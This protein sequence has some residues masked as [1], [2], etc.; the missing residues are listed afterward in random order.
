MTLQLKNKKW[1]IVYVISFLLFSFTGNAAIPEEPEEEILFVTSYNSDT[2]YTYDNINTFVETYRQL[3]GKYSTIVENMNVTDLNQSRK[4]KKRLTNILDKH[5]NAKLVILLGGE[6][7]SSFLHLEDEKY[8]QLPV[9]C[10]MASRN[11]IRI[12]EDSIDIRT[13]EPQ[14]IDLTERM[15]KYNIIYCNTY[16]YDIDK[17][18]EMMRSFYP[19]M[20]H[21]V[22]ISDNTYNGLAEQAWVKKNMKRYPEISTTYIDG[23][24]HTLDAAVKQ[25]RDVPKNSVALLGIWRI[26]N[27]GITYMNNSVYAFS[28]ANPELPVFS[29]TATAI[30]YWAI[31][32]YIPQYDGIGKSMG[33]QAYQFLDKGKNNVGHIHLLPNRYKFDANKLHEWG[34]QDKK[35]PFNSLIINQQ[36]PFF[37]AYR[38]EVQFILFTFLVLI[39][40]LFISLYY[41]YRTKILK[42]HLEKTTAQLR[43]DKKKLELSEIALRHAKERAEEA[44]Q[45]K[46][47]FV[48][49]MS[50]EIRTPLNAIVGFSRIISESENPEER[51]E[52]YE[53]VDANNER[54]LQ[55]INEILDLSKIESGIVEFT[56]GPVKLHTLCKEIHDAHVFRCPQGVELKFD[57]PDEAL[58]IHSD[59]NRIFQV[60]SNLIG[61]AFKFT[62]Q[63]SVSYGYR[64]EAEKVVFYVKDTGLGIEPEKLGRVFQ[65]FAKLNNFAQGTGLGL[66]IC[67]TII[68]R[69]GGEISV[70]SEVGTGTTFTFWLPLESVMQDVKADKEEHR[71]GETDNRQYPEAD[72]RTKEPAESKEERKSMEVT[73]AET[74]KATILIAEDT[75]SNYDL[76]NAILGRKYHLVRARDGMEAVTMY[77]EAEPDLILMDIK[78]PNLDGLEATRIIRQ[79]S[80]DVPIIA[81]SAYAYEYDRK[82]AEEAGCNDFISKPIAQ[83]KLKEMIKKWLR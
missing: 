51:K 69:L 4:W 21:L 55:L 26:D 77:D 65:R 46:S 14:S 82:A 7:W 67:K 52:Y 63:G 33:E 37:Q 74:D 2:K 80:A 36:V 32:G 3:G 8:R 60:F 15:N 17:D 64:Q 45:L 10:A 53:I 31:G 35:L 81:Q 1:R 44:N 18:I 28:K 23:R 73:E 13:Y 54:L 27:R 58:S 68:E 34:F 22:F 39:G 50:H 11:G 59:K 61:N 9:F 71:D 24:I 72:D 79:L 41:Y 62:T 76:L 40:G 42:N 38:T 78:M 25:L 6:A 20:E 56:Y 30:G 12:P 57:S 47:A 70:S 48:S 19:D 16:E 49:N 83:E 75:D 66:S 5:P 43:E 29:L